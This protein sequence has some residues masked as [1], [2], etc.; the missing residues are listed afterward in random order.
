M[1]AIM[2]ENIPDPLYHRLTEMARSHHHSLSK[3]IVAALEHYA[4]PPNQEDKLELL[5][6]IR[7]VR[8]AYPSSISAADVENWKEMGRP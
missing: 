8:N 5:E 7:A 6:R 4:R 2:L 1:P 3:E